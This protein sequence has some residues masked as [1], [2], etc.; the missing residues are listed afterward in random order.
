MIGR[1]CPWPGCR[2]SVRAGRLMCPPHWYRLPA[3]I[4][5]RI[6]A[7]Y[8]RGQTALTCSPE[9]RDALREALAFARQAA[10]GER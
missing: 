5:A 4:R 7:T 3:G 1:A 9:Y 8:R 10:G 6:W 2:R